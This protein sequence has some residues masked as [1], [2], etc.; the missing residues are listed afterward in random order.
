[1]RWEIEFLFRTE[2]VKG[3]DFGG[4]HRWDVAGDVR[5]VQSKVYPDAPTGILFPSDPGISSGLAPDYY[6]AFMPRI[7]FAWDP[8]GSGKWSVRSGYGIFYDGFSNASTSPR[9]RP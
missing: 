3:I 8:T 7:G 9:I 5:G 4:T 1:M 6:K 2:G